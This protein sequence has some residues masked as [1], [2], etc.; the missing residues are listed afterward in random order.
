M[1]ADGGLGRPVADPALRKPNAV[2]AALARAEE[3]ELRAE[4]AEAHSHALADALEDAE[5]RAWRAEKHVLVAEAR[6]R[7]VLEV[8]RRYRALIANLPDTTLVVFDRDLRYLVYEGS[9]PDS[10]G[11]DIEG[12]AVGDI[13]P[14]KVARQLEELYRRVLSGQSPESEI[15]TDGR[16]YLVQGVPLP[17]EEGVGPRGMVLSRDI[18]RLKQAEAAL[19]QERETLRKTVEERE[20]LLR[21]VYHRVKNNLQVVSS[22]LSLQSR[23]LDD[24]AAKRALTAC[25]ERVAA[26][27]RVHEQLYRS[28]DV[29]NI[30][31]SAYLRELV[32][33]VERT[34]RVGQRVRVRTHFDPVLVDLGCGIPVGLIAHELL[35]NAFQHAFPEQ[36]EGTI[37]LE[38]RASGDTFEL[39]V[40]DDG[41][42][43]DDVAPHALGT[44]LIRSLAH[45]IDATM[46]SRTG[47][48]QG[49]TWTLRAPRQTPAS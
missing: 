15:I 23:T 29:A 17:A 9:V 47:P 35:A 32:R 19:R 14:P 3:A 22:L 48:G 38:L 45:Q 33:E 44:R 13:F 42:G 20:V 21:E 10:I 41:V 5:R 24:P 30:E 40:A 28:A 31:L 49:S 2:E 7:R 1:R 11:H 46:D 25:R 36:A 26:M 6:A 34:Y 27:G 39:I 16:S 12:S 18:T 43:I 37:R 4:R 8:S